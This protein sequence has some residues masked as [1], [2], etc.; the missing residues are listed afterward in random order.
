MKQFLFIFIRC[1]FPLDLI[2]I[3]FSNEYTLIFI[4]IHFISPDTPPKTDPT[5]DADQDV[6]IN[7]GYTDYSDHQVNSPVLKNL[8]PGYMPAN[9]PVNKQ[10]V[11]ANGSDFYISPREKNRLR[12]INSDTESPIRK[13]KGIHIPSHQPGF[14]HF[15]NDDSPRINNSFNS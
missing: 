13:S 5:S 7:Q 9:V 3:I 2:L 8:E 1:C 12:S 14:R 4:C 11:A 15:L 10:P 6:F